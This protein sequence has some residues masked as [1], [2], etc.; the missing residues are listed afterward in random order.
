MGEVMP[1][2]SL[3]RPAGHA[4][5]GRL[6]STL[7]S[8][9]WRASGRGPRPAHDLALRRG[10]N[11]LMPPAGWQSPAQADCCAPVGAGLRPSLGCSVCRGSRRTRGATLCRTGGAKSVVE[12]RF[13]HAPQTSAPRHP[14]SPRLSQPERAFGAAMG[15]CDDAA[16]RRQI[17]AA[18]P[19][20]SGRYFRCRSGLCRQNDRLLDPDRR[21]IAQTGDNTLKLMGTNS[22]DIASWR[23][24]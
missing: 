6:A 4:A 12:V 5:A 3:N 11:A 9:L 21:S 20:P 2:Q 14:K 15:S 10:S 22:V 23:P 13:A 8:G 1:N 18:R 19:L 7:T 24:W 16:I 17:N